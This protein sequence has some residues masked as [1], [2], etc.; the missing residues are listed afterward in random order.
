MRRIGN[1][2]DCASSTLCAG[3]IG[4]LRTRQGLDLLDET[5]F[6][7]MRAFKYGTV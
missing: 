3:G 1:R 4:K 6:G 7:R 2:I 5:Y